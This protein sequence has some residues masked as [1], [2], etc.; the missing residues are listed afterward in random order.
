MLT[1]I[2]RYRHSVRI[3]LKRSAK[4]RIHLFIKDTITNRYKKSLKESGEHFEAFESLARIKH[5]IGYI[6]NGAKNSYRS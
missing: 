2:N 6:K 4:I 3:F 1:F 5:K